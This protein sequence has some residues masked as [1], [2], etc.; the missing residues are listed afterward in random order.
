MQ[1]AARMGCWNASRA[2]S[3]ALGR[4][5]FLIREAKRAQGPPEGTLTHV[6]TRGARISSYRTRRHFDV[7][8]GVKLH[9]DHSFLKRRLTV[10]RVFHHNARISGKVSRVMRDEGASSHR[11]CAAIRLSS[12]SFFLDNIPPFSD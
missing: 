3:S 12:A 2:F 11:A 6:K 5:V 1:S 8:V 7:P 10:Q 4:R 9:V